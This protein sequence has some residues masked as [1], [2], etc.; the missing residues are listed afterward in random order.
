MVV[1]KTVEEKFNLH[2]KR[3]NK[4]FAW[5]VKKGYIGMYNEDLIIKLRTIY[6][7]GIPA[8]ILL[9]SNGMC[10]GHCY[11]R[12]LLLSRAFLNEE[13][14]VK[15]IYASINSLRLNPK[16]I[17]DADPLYADHCIVERITKDGQHIIYDT[18]T[19][20]IYDKE[21]YWKMEHPK[22]RKINNKKSIIDY[23]KLDEDCYPEDVERDKYASV[24]TLPILEMTCKNLG[25]F[26]AN[27]GIKLLQREIELFKQLIDYNSLCKEVDEDMIRLGL[28]R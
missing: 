18:S 15:L 22:V 6:Y 19:G 2:K 9:L 17:N 1:I 27:V 14:D 5:G 3:L 8:S 25:E 26:Y 13:D 24:I 4:L 28:K 12:A 10:N 16:F 20:F 21:L 11:D 7:G 23:I